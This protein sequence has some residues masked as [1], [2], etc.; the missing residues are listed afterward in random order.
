MTALFAYL[1]LP[2]ADL[3]TWD[4]SRVETMDGMFYKST[5]NNDSICG[6]DVSSCLTFENMFRYCSFK[7]NVDNWDIGHKPVPKKDKYGN[8]IKDASGNPQFD[9]IPVDPPL[10]GAAE[11]E[12]RELK[13]KRRLKLIQ[14][15]V[16]ESN[17]SNIKNIKTMKHI[18]DYDTF[19]NEGF[20]DFVKKGISKIQ[21]FFKN[22]TMKFGNLIASFDE[23][24]EIL[25]ASSPY[26]AL[27]YISDGAVEGVT[28][29]TKVK[30]DFIN[31]NVKSIAPLIQSP[32]YYGI[33][34]KN[35]IEYKNYLTML[36][37]I[38]EHYSKYGEKLN[39]NDN[40]GRVGL[41]AESGGLIDVED[42]DSKKFKD[43]LKDAIKDVPG[44][45]RQGCTHVIWG[46]PGIGKS[47]IPNA[48]INEWNKNKDINSKKALMVVECGN[49]TVDGFSLPMPL[50]KKIGNYMKD[51]PLVA[52]KIA[53]K[54]IDI[55]KY[56]DERFQVS[57][58]AIK[59]WVPCYRKTSD[60]DLN[61]ALN[62]ICNG[63]VVLKNNKDKKIE[64]IVTTEGGIILFDEFF[65]ANPNVFKILMQIILN[66]NFNDEFIIGDKWAIIAC[67]NRPGD[68]GEV[69]QSY[70]K[71]S[72]ALGNRVASYNFIPD[73]S[74]W[75]EWAIKEGQFD[76]LTLQFLM[77]N[78]DTSEKTLG[79]FTNWH[80]ANPEQYKL[81]KISWPSPRSWAQT[82]ERIH[83]RMEDAG[84]EDFIEFISDADNLEKVRHIASGHL[85]KTLAGNYVNFLKS[86]IDSDFNPLDVLNN[87][88][89]KIPQEIS[90][91]EIIGK[92]ENYIVAAF[93][94]NTLPSDEQMMNLFKQMETNYSEF[95]NLLIKLYSKAINTFGFNDNINANKYR[96]NIMKTLPNFMMKIGEKYNF[97]DAN[98]MERFLNHGKNLKK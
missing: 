3:H 17:E 38:N 70:S 63:H 14:G 61:K 30:N 46:A 19:I 94:K 96:K 58:E 20:K 86:Y 80:N 5:F 64:T 55:D 85:G 62:D 41:S 90:A 65:R 43:L 10:V 71:T 13:K 25:D 83:Y 32:E 47:T 27:N 37:M 45:K 56:K 36:D 21:S 26:T 22:I 66:R 15:S 28:A 51:N 68:D 88:K 29:Y 87:P 78:V 59:T 60:D 6:W 97:N 48:V 98:S 91:S 79:E 12:Y 76:P 2:K 67:T 1:D 75:K 54:N 69:R 84:I 95:S 42:I 34:D 92:L 39:E 16:T 49:L 57:G 35:S 44:E 73:F 31:D 7:H 53:N 18:L 82:I 40:S 72:S 11:N 9:Y 23:Q 77:K 81:G 33:I 89:Y 24:G 74:E 93:S 8:I 50:I 52:Q 4:T